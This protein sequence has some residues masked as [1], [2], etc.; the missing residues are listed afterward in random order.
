MP[1]EVLNTLY[2]QTQGAV[3]RL[4]HDTVRVIVEQETLLRVPLLRLNGIVVLGNVTVTPFLIHRCAEDGRSLVWLSRSGRFRARAQG[5]VRG[6][7]LLRR[8]QHLAVDEQKTCLHIARQVVAAK[9]Q[10]CRQVLMRGARENKA[11]IE[12]NALRAEADHLASVLERLP[13][14]NDLDA[15][16]GA[17]GE[18]AR[19]YFGVFGYMVRT[20]RAEFAMHGRTRRPP[21]DRL[22]SL[23]SFYYALLRGECEAAAEGVGLDPQ[24]GFLHALRSG[25]PALALDLMEPLRPV[26]ADRLALTLVNRQQLKPDDFD[27][28]PGGVR[29]TEQGRKTVLVAFQKRKEAEVHHRVLDR[30]IPLGLVAHAQARLLARYLRGDLEIYPSYVYR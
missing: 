24:V 20:N 2:V 5:G 7:V 29:L 22:N 15:L 1:T 14:V 17:E 11:V 27:V 16:R 4:E 19:A 8:A 23:L 3:L 13:S 18:A 9:I 30:K 28:T 25:R 21:L 26:L 6:N 12:R 10:N